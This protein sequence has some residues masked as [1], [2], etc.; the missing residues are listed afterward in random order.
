MRS[1]SAADIL[2]VWDRHE[3]LHPLLRAQALLGVAFP[4]RDA[5]A[6]ADLTVGERDARL[7]ALR[8]RSFGSA[9]KG[10]GECLVCGERIEFNI[11]TG[12]LAPA[13]PC[14]IS[15]EV[16]PLVVDDITV[17]CRLPSV[18]DLCAAAACGDPDQGRRLLARRCV[19]EV[20]AGGAP[21]PWEE[22]EPKLIG[23]LAAHLDAAD[24]YAE[25]NLGFACPR[26]DHRWQRLMDIASFFWVEVAVRAKRLVGEVHVLARAY[27]WQERDVLAMSP[28][29]RRMYLDLVSA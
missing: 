7:F 17:R 22:L 1:L 14:F 27:G 13:N 28:R 5:D 3:G 15:G 18:R 16:P 19:I 25:V 10:Y 20:R 29:R 11:P 6:L 24:P 21:V 8:R 26:C 9:M 12:A 2:D 4:E 23:P